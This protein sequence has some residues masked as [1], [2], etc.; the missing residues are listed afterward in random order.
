MS[1]AEKPE[2]GWRGFRPIGAGSQ[3]FAHLLLHAGFESGAANRVRRCR[4]QSQ[5]ALH[6]GAGV[7][8]SQRQHWRPHHPWLAINT[9][10]ASHYPATRPKG[11]EEINIAELSFNASP[12]QTIAKRHQAARSCGWK[13][14]SNIELNGL[15]VISHHQLAHSLLIA[16]RWLH[17]SKCKECNFRCENLRL[18]QTYPAMLGSFALATLPPTHTDGEPSYAD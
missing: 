4:D 8:R 1:S 9:N 11:V 17:V 6:R 14:E 15:S 3:C 18:G 12:Q 5:N 13:L 10:A 7:D 2:F 16:L